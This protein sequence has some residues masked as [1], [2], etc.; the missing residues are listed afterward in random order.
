[1]KIITF[2]IYIVEHFLNPKARITKGRVTY[3]FSY[4]IRNALYPEFQQ[5]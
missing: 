5:N 1:M 2:A 4:A 3:R